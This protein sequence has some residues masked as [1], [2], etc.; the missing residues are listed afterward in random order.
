MSAPNSHETRHMRCHA[1][2]R[3]TD[4]EMLHGQES[5]ARASI[6]RG[7]SSRR[8][9][10]EFLSIRQEKWRMDPRRRFRGCPEI[11]DLLLHQR[12][13]PEAEV[14]LFNDGKPHIFPMTSAP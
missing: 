7:K 14:G 9:E 12:L 11:S 6:K 10:D 8:A 4:I 13:G 3:M 5:A 1:R 2:D